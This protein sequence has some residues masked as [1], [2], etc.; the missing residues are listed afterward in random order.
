M[1]SPHG[2]HEFHG[3]HGASADA[4][5][6]TRRRIS[7]PVPPGV[8]PTRRTPLRGPFAPLQALQALRALRS[9]GPPRHPRRTLRD[10]A[11]RHVLPGPL[12][13]RRRP[14]LR[15]PLR[16]ARR[17][18]LE[19]HR[20]LERARPLLGV[21]RQTGPHQR[22]QRVRNPVQLRLLV[23]HPVEH[24]LRTAVPEGRVG[25]RGVGQRRA[26]REDVGR[27]GHRRATYLLGRQEA[28]RPHRR[29][30]VRERARPGR[31]G[32]PEVDDAR[33]FGGEQ[34]VRRLQITV[35]HPGLVHRQQPLGERG[36]HGGDL[37]GRQR[38]VLGDLV[39]QR[40]P[41]YVLGGEPRPVRVEIGGHQPG[42]TAS[43]DPAG[44]RDLAGEPG[45]ELLVL[46]EIGPDHLQRDPLAAPVGSQV[47]DPHAALPQPPVNPERTD[48]TRVLAPEPHHRHVHPRCP[49]VRVTWHSL[50]TRAPG[51]S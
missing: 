38:P 26:E 5:P 41:R 39:V 32:D 44:R 34:D 36:S 25:R 12:P 27:R 16:L 35:D 51:R 15:Q 4:R 48:D 9:L 3:P 31:P 8:G 21:L 42:R 33:A 18:L 40:G 6:R 29:T 17:D 30:D 28:G 22:R 19:P 49:V 47:D 13:L 23:H 37:G 14:S 45:A 50:R 10:P 46:G 2:P 43:A 20:Q 1:R 11:R 7:R 24:D